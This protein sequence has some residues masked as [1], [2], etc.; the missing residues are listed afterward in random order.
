MNNAIVSIIDKRKKVYIITAKT[1][2]METS[3]CEKNCVF[4]KVTY[5]TVLVAQW[6]KDL[7]LSLL[8]LGLLLWHRFN[9]CPRI[10]YMSWPWPKKK[11]KAIYFQFFFFFLS[12]L[13]GCPV[14]YGVL[15]PG[16][17][18]KPQL[19][20]ML[21]LCQHWIPNPLCWAGDRTCISVFQRCCRS[22]C[23]TA[24]TSYC[25]F[26]RWTKRLSGARLTS[27]ICKDTMIKATSNAVPW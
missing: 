12:F 5:W 6:V 13:F 27:C 21:Q 15:R 4:Q 23:T 14:A 10:F 26:W 9:L 1:L 22:C 20:P 8:W 3:Y 18:S 17:R 7:A 25:Q 2:K 11:K 24:G 16:I 19:W